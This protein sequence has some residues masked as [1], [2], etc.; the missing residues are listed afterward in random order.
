MGVTDGLAT[1]FVSFTLVIDD[2][3]EALVVEPINT[4][5]DMG[6][7]TVNLRQL[8]TTQEF[9]AVVN[10]G[11]Q[12]Y[13]GINIDTASNTAVS[14]AKISNQGQLDIGFADFGHRYF[15]SSSEVDMDELYDLFVAPDGSNDL[16]A[17]GRHNGDVV[18]YRL[19][20][21]GALEFTYELYNPDEF[22]VSTMKDRRLA[23]IANETTPSDYQLVFAYRHDTLSTVIATRY[24]ADGTMDTTFGTSGVLQLSIRESLQDIVVDDASNIYF[25]GMHS[26]TNGG[27]ISAFDDSGQSIQEVFINDASWIGS[28]VASSTQDILIAGSGFDAGL[29]TPLLW[30]YQ[31]SESSLTRVNVHEVPLTGTDA[32]EFWL[33]EIEYVSEYPYCCKRYCK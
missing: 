7:R 14:L 29:Y 20:A 3:D 31:L 17:F 26:P 1:D 33:D 15:D 27:Y 18:L 10:N 4:F 25:F 23:I 16:I 6:T 5:A 24:E 12:M 19:D 32:N 21:S 13:V 22:T 9:G 2:V 8:D 28:A 30:H 11:G